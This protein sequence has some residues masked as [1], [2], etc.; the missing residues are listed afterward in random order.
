MKKTLSFC[1]VILFLTSCVEGI[2]VDQKRKL[3]ALKHD[4][5]EHYQEEKKV[6]TAVGLGFLPGGGSF[7]TRNYM[8]GVLDLLSWPVSI[9]WDPINGSNGAEEINYYASI[10]SLKRAKKKELSAL[11]DRLLEKKISQTEYLIQ[12]KKIEKKYDL[13][14]M[15]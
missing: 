5:P 4:M 11:E 7:Y 6:G 2:S 1:L 14:N 13:D 15:I 3:T 8:I 12:Q 9:L 10:S